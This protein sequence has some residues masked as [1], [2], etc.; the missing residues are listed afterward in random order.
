[1]PS[2]RRPYRTPHPTALLR[3]ASSIF[4]IVKVRT[5]RRVYW[6]VTHVPHPFAPSGADDHR[7]CG[8]SSHT[9]ARSKRAALIVSW[10]LHHLGAS[11][12]DIQ[13]ALFRL[14]HIGGTAKDAVLAYAD[15]QRTLKQRAHRIEQ[16]KLAEQSALLEFFD[17]LAR[18]R[19]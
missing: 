9:D 10:C 2:Y 18:S 13:Q 6:E 4:P 15:H 12:E 14:R 11:P 8:Y 17:G 16:S 1:M 19:K 7:T 3:E 5:R